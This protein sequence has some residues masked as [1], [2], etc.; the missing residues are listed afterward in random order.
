MCHGMAPML[1]LKRAANWRLGRAETFMSGSPLPRP[2]Q[3]G[4]SIYV[5]P[6]TGHHLYF[7][8]RPSR[9]R[10]PSRRRVPL[11]QP[12]DIYYDDAPPQRTGQCGDSGLIVSGKPVFLPESK[13]SENM[14]MKKK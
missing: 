5:E 12:N 4:T 6:G 9:D 8:P 13:V 7:R 11:N 2:G 14:R 10:Q 1:S 3:M